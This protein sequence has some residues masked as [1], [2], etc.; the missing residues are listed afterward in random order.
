MHGGKIT[1][2]PRPERRRN[3]CCGMSEPIWDGRIS[4]GVSRELTY[5]A[6]KKNGRLGKNWKEE[7]IRDT[8]T[9]FQMGGTLYRIKQG[10]SQEK[11]REEVTAEKIS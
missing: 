4:V 5:S 6:E 10:I 9:R 3:V 1:E 7:R 8:P 11:K 2:K